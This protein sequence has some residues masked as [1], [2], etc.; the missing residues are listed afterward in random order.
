MCTEFDFLP[1]QVRLI[2]HKWVMLILVALLIAAYSW[3]SR[4]FD[5]VF[6]PASGEKR[7]ERRSAWLQRHGIVATSFCGYSLDPRSYANGRPSVE[8]WK[9]DK[10]RAAEEECGPKMQL[11]KLFRDDRVNAVVAIYRC[12][13]DGLVVERLLAEY[14]GASHPTNRW[15]SVGVFSVSD[16][17]PVGGGVG[18]WK[19]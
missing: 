13:S 14:K 5:Q 4:H 2:K 19:E 11:T 15:C 3:P 17:I 10:A 6:W 16:H 8:K 12:Q 7:L 1:W 9:K 18:Y